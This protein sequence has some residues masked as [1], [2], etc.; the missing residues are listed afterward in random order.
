MR[1]A[2]WQAALVM[3]LSGLILGAPA[4]RGL[5]EP[6]R[7]SQ[8]RQGFPRESSWNPDVVR[9]FDTRLEQRVLDRIELDSFLRERAIRLAVTGGTVIITGE[10]WTPLERQR[11][12]E[13]VCSVEGVVDVV[14]H[15]AVR[16]PR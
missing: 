7:P 1:L 2:L 3:T 4:C 10:V 6:S 16:P 8:V 12:G 9:A 15:L 5:D 13:I 14:N 11:A